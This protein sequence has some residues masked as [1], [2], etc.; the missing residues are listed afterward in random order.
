VIG[1]SPGGDVSIRLDEGY[2]RVGRDG[3]VRTDPVLVC[4]AAAA[5]AVCGPEAAQ[6]V[7]VPAYQVAQRT[8]QGYTYVTHDYARTLPRAQG[9]TVDH[10]VVAA[11]AESNAFCR[12]W[13]TVALTRHRED[14]QVHLSAAGLRHDRVLTYEP[15][16][17][18]RKDRQEASVDR[19]QYAMPEVYDPSSTSE[20]VLD[21]K[22]RAEA[23]DK[24]AGRLAQDRPGPS[25]LDYQEAQPVERWQE[26]G[27][28]SALEADMSEERNPG[29]NHALDGVMFEPDLVIEKGGI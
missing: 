28:G 24:A 25:T 4:D 1:I 20:P 12:Q 27:A 13:G 8:S 26:M 5:R 19:G 11:Y 16:H 17:W 21:N 22:A 14:V 3:T 7:N 15:A 29:H 23:L 9:V 10:A 6:Y 18:P 2:K